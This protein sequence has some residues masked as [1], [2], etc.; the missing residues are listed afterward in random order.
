M[1]RSLVYEM[2]LGSSKL[3]LSRDV[4]V[5]LFVCS[6]ERS[7]T[8][9][10]MNALATCTNYTVNNHL[11][12]DYDPFGSVVDFYSNKSIAYFINS[13]SAVNYANNTYS[14]S[15]I[16]KSHHRPWHL[17]YI[18]STG[19]PAIYIMRNPVDVFIS[20]WKMVHK[21]NWLCDQTPFPE[22]PYLFCKSSPSGR[23]L[24][25]QTYQNSTFF[26][27][28]ATHLTEWLDYVDSN[29]TNIAVLNYFDL[30]DNFQNTVKNVVNK[31]NL[32]LLN[33]PIMPSKNINVVSGSEIYLSNDDIA[34]LRDYC[35][36][37]IVEYP[38]LKLIFN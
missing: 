36:D 21:W 23:A 15:S 14:L 6:H 1:H 16:I 24:N 7:G 13:L 19:F 4:R 32:D 8:H 11:N 17:K 20:F 37:R 25:Y 10:I 9:F 29:P 30:V 33:E 31:L 18:L 3:N 2:S 38:R 28:W 35:Y 12:L 26:D 5:P 34:N 27:R 22:S